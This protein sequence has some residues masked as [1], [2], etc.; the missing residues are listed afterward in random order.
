[1]SPVRPPRLVLFDIDG[2]LLSCGR[3]VRP[4]FRQAL[5]EVFGPEVEIDVEDYDFAGKTDPRIVVDLVTAGGRPAAQVRAAL[6]R[7]RERFVALLD[8]RLRS[9]HVRVLPGVSELLA[10]L[11][12]ASGLTLGLVTG[13]WS[14]GA[15]VKLSRAGLTETFA[16][17]AFGDDGEDR[18]LLPP[19]ALERAAELMGRRLDPR[20]VLLI[21][22]TPLDVACARAHGIPVLAVATGS[23]GAE[24]LRA[25]GA[26]WVVNDLRAARRAVPALAALPVG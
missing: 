3:H 19:R 8:R 4:I 15:R 9:E 5:H 21:G 7:M 2:T 10:G 26:D 16:C 13:N 17:G 14:D 18:N 20:E 23:C 6:G 1:M 22:D 24:S 11:G 12:S 25:A